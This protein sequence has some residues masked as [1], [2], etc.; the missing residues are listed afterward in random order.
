MKKII[1]IKETIIDYAFTPI[2]ENS[3]KIEVESGKFA[4]K[5]YVKQIFFLKDIY[6]NGNPTGKTERIYLD[7]A[8]LKLIIKECEEIEKLETIKEIDEWY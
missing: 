6:K 1:D 2:Y 4:H 7:V 8:H 3:K 5:G